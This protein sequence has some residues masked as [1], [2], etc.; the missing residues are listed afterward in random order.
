MV[1]GPTVTV[2]NGET[3]DFEIERQF[4]GLGGIGGQTGGNGNTGGTTGQQSN[5]LQQV[6]MSVSPQITQVGEIRLEIQD[7]QLQDFGNP[8]PNSQLSFVDA[9]GNDAYT[10]NEPLVTGGYNA[11]QFPYDVRTRS[12][13]TVARVRNHGTIVLGGWTGEHSRTADSGVPILRNLPYVGKLLFGRTSD[14]IEKTS[15]LIFLTCHLVEP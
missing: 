1:N 13:Q 3:A 10:E 6:Q 14:R 4:P 15:L 5:T 2:E 11:G 7:L 8:L 12:L 9:D